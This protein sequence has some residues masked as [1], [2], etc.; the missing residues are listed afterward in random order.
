MGD[1]WNLNLSFVSVG[2]AA[3]LLSGKGMLQDS[4]WLWAVNCPFCWGAS[5]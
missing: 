5:G 4:G 1:S 2:T 3:F